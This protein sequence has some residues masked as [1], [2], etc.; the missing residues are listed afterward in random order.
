MSDLTISPN[1]LIVGSTVISSG[2]VSRVLFEGT[3]N[4]LQEDADFTFDTATNTLF[5]PMVTGGT[6]TTNSLTLSAYDDA[7]DPA[8]TGRLSIMER[9]TFTESYSTSAAV[10]TAGLSFSGTHTT[11]N[12]SYA[13]PAVQSTIAV[14]Y[15]VSQTASVCST[16]SAGTVYSPT[17]NGISDTSGTVIWSGFTSGPKF[18][19]KGSGVSATTADLVAF[20]AYP[21]SSLLSSATAGTVTN[22]TCFGAWAPSNV[23]V[24]LFAPPLGASTTWTNCRAVWIKQASGTGSI[25]NNY[26]ID[27]ENLTKGSTIIAGIRNQITGATG[28]Y[29]IYS[30]GDAQ[31]VHAGLFNFGSTT[32]PTALVDI[33][34]STTARSSLRIKSGTAPTSPNSGDVWH[35]STRQCLMVYCGGM[36]LGL[37]KVGFVQTA[38]ANLNTSVTETTLIGTGIGTATLPANFLTIGKTIRVKMMGFYGTKASPVGAL[39][40]RLKYGSTTLLTLSPTLVVSLTNQPF[41]LDFDITCRTTGATGTVFAQGIGDFYSAA[42]TSGPITGVTTATTTIDTTASS[43]IDITFQ[44]ATS[45]ANNTVTS[46]NYTMEVKY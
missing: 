46:T 16:F 22:L 13:F 30:S 40:V 14:E 10:S 27:I 34:G 24:D 12:A 45:N 20:T 4:L 43:K 11:S 26:G 3:G 42:A 23:I 44:W 7:F 8:N 28:K 33:D 9:M 31:S 39:T 6:A 25:T 37:T 1:S 21:S 38:N 29:F 41:F 19:P 18:S 15:S 5:V 2:T 17:T 35:D 36:T 32:V